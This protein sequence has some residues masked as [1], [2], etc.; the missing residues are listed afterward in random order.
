VHKGTIHR[1]NNGLCGYGI[2]L[3]GT[4]GVKYTYCHA[5]QINVSEGATVNAGALIMH[6]G[7]Q[8]GTAGAGDATGPHLHF[9]MEVN[10]ANTC[11]QALLQ[12]W[13]AGQFASPMNQPTSG[14]SSST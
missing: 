11:P 14:C 9:G 8:P 5:S 4:D 12:K 13:E 7:G 2:E 1:V 10:G 3:Q 6:S